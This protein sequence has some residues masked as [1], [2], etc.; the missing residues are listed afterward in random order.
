M[1]GRRLK[2]GEAGLTLIEL[3]FTVAIMSVAFVVILSGMITAVLGAT[4]HRHQA[5]GEAVLRS[6]AEAVKAE[7]YVPCGT[8]ASYGGTY[9]P[10]PRYRRT[11]VNVEYLDPAWQYASTAP[12]PAFVDTCLPDHDPG[13]Q[14]LTLEVGSDD[15]RSRESVEV[16]KRGVP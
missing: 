15:G 13:I 6:F 16:L 2:A 11:V 10:P 3:I 5:N 4:L 12:A 8:E 7:P 1:S 9:S 14:R